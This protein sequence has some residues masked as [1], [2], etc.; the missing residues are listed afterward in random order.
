MNETPLYVRVAEALG[1]QDVRLAGGL[2]S[3]MASCYD[4]RPPGQ[5]VIIGRPTEGIEKVPRYDLEWSATGP[6]IEKYRLTLWS[7]T[8]AD[9]EAGVGSGW[10]CNSVE[11]QWRWTSCKGDTAL[12]A[13]CEYLLLLK[14][15]GKLAA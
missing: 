1:W 13:V 9:E 7:H 10:Y 3:P 5:V 6:L 8:K 15:A 14:E 12:E 2:L 4:G 11:P